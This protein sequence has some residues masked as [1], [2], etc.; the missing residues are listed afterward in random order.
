MS[1]FIPWI[2]GRDPAKKHT[3]LEADEVLNLSYG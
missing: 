3:L 2:S 1:Y